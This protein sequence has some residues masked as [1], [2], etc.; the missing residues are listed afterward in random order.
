MRK[1]VVD[2]A[3]FIHD[4]RG[5]FVGRVPGKKIGQRHAVHGS[6]FSRLDE[7]NTD[8]PKVK[9]VHW[10]NRSKLL[11][12]TAHEASG[13]YFGSAFRKPVHAYDSRGSKIGTFKSHAEAV[14]E[15]ARRHTKK[16]RNDA[17]KVDEI[18]S[19]TVG[20]ILSK[21]ADTVVGERPYL[22]EGSHEHFIDKIRD[23]IVAGS[24]CPYAP[25]KPAPANEPLV[26]ISHWPNVVATF[27]DRGIVGCTQCGKWWEIPFT[28][29]SKDGE[30]IV[31]CGTPEERVQAYVTPETAAAES[32]P[33]SGDES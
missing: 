22:V 1:T 12:Y 23:P 10:Y 20:D 13:E 32:G 18:F 28:I 26:Y 30:E 5:H 31:E 15:I 25:G 16:R 19:N 27:A 7:V 29:T 8:D 17:M 2:S 33:P 3:G 6:G 14:S 9:S 4:D 24:G 11:G 21:A